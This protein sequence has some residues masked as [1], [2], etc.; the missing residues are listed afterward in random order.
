MSKAVTVLASPTPSCDSFYNA[1]IGKYELVTIPKQ[2][3]KIKDQV[4]LI[5]MRRSKDKVLSP[6]LKYEIKSNYEDGKN[7]VLFLNRRGFARVFSCF[8]CGYIPTCPQCGIP[9]I[10]HSDGKSFVC[11]ICK[12]KETVFDF[13]PKCKGS[14]FTYQGI[15]TQKIESEVKKI[16]RAVDKAFGDVRQS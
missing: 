11:H 3:K 7:I 10:F 12:Y 9:L 16:I 6:K 15:G 5:D 2:D 14:D 8:D 1:K 13:C 4:V